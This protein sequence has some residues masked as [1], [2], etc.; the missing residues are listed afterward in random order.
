MYTTK[1]YKNSSS[2]LSTTFYYGQKSFS[3]NSNWKELTHWKSVENSSNEPLLSVVDYIC[4]IL[5]PN[6][7]LW[8]IFFGFSPNIIQFPYDIS[9]NILFY[10]FKTVP[11]L[12]SENFS[13]ALF[14]VHKKHWT[15]KTFVLSKKKFRTIFILNIEV[16]SFQMSPIPLKR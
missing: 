8:P 13:L 15:Y 16:L 12:F 6:T 1:T 7:A 4:C 9:R 2:F 11:S 5:T 14:I 3:P 10:I